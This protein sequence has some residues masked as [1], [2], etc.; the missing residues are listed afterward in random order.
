MDGMEWN[1]C[2]S[3]CITYTYPTYSLNS[4][5]HLVTMKNVVA[6]WMYVEQH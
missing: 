4:T 6:K 1:E 3:N 5:S 2:C